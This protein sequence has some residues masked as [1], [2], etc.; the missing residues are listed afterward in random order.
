MNALFQP[1]ADVIKA[2]FK[3][4]SRWPRANEALFLFA[5]TALGLIGNY[6]SIGLFL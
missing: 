5:L 2:F 3:S 6:L 4:S 1:T